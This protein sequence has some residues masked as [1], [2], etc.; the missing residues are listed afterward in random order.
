MRVLISVRVDVGLVGGECVEERHVAGGM[1]V[2]DPVSS[3]HRV[4]G[5]HPAEL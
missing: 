1:R 3:V 5:G 2:D 4:V